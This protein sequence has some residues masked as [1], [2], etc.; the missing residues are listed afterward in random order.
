[1]NAKKSLK[2][3]KLRSQCLEKETQVTSINSGKNIPGNQQSVDKCTWLTMWSRGIVKAQE[4]YKVL[5]SD[6][7]IVNS[8]K[9]RAQEMKAMCLTSRH[10]CSTSKETLGK[11]PRTVMLNIEKVTV[12]RK[13]THVS[14]AVV[15]SDSWILCI[16]EKQMAREINKA[17]IAVTRRGPAKYMSV[18]KATA[19]PLVF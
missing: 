17:L 9:V 2:Y 4:V 5:T 12:S 1:M 10:R 16:Q 6:I 13:K 8:G 11:G 18:Q 15:S 19:R 3:C 7:D 14:I